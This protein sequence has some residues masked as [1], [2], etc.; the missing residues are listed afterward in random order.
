MGEPI[1]PLLLAKAAPIQGKSEYYEEMEQYQAAQAEAAQKQEAV[2]QELLQAQKDLATS[3]SLQQ[4]AGAKE[5]FTRAVANMGLEDERA[6]EAVQNRTQAVLD[7]AKAIQVLE[8][9]D[10]K[11]AEDELRLAALLR[12]KNRLEEEQ[13]K[14]DDVT[15]SASVGGIVSPEGNN[16][17]PQEGQ[18][19][20][21]Q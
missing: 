8:D 9:M 2:Q 6:S 5:R 1:P 17:L 12:E 21:L 11:T 19:E 15:I 10:L 14:A 20:R 3:Q 18:N 16:Q 13:I 4:V 7:Q